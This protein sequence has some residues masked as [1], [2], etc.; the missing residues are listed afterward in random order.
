MKH[1]T[2]ASVVTRKSLSELCF[3]VL[4]TEFDIKL[5]SFISFRPFSGV[6]IYKI[7]DALLP[8]TQNLLLNTLSYCIPLFRLFTSLSAIHNK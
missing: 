7:Y 6:R 5:L 3:E 2:K 1:N 8:L 4:S